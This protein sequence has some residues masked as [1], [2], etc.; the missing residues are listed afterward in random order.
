MMG[1]SVASNQSDA[2]LLKTLTDPQAYADRLQ[3]LTDKENDA[4]AVLE[5]AKQNNAK[6]EEDLKHAGELNAATVELMRKI[7]EKE[8]DLAAREGGLAARATKIDAAG[9]QLA[10]QQAAF[11]AEYKTKTGELQ[12]RERAVVD[13]EQGL[14]RKAKELDDSAAQVLAD[15]LAAFEKDCSIKISVIDARAAEVAAKLQEVDATKAKVTALQN[16]LERKI[17]A[18]KQLAI[19]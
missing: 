13:V 9:V 19:S 14:K 6:S 1:A 8:A 5:Q 15:K 18:M 17:D 12:A 16:E 11:D 7:N 10:S 2:D 4:K 3:K